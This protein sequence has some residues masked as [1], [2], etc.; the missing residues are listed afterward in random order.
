M[1]L[2]GSVLEQYSLTLMEAYS[3]GVPCIGLRPDWKTVFN[4]NEDQ[5]Q[6]GKTGFVVRDEAEMADRIDYLLS[7]EEERREMGRRAYELKKE[8]FSFEAFYSDIKSAC[9]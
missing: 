2:T 5:I 3:F 6:E 1:L 8:S 9:S 4:S 7:H